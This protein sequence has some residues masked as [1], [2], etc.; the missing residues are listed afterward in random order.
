MN[1]LKITMYLLLTAIIFIGCEK[2]TTTLPENA[3]TNVQD[4]KTE[5]QLPLNSISEIIKSGV[6]LK[7]YFNS[8]P[9]PE[10]TGSRPAYSQISNPDLQF[11]YSTEGWSCN[12]MPME[13]FEDANNYGSLP[14]YLN[15][16]SDNSIFSP[17][18]ILPG[19]SFELTRNDDYSSPGYDSFDW[20]MNNYGFYVW[21]DS[22]WGA[23][24]A[25]LSNYNWT[26]L[27]INFS[28]NNVTN[29]SMDL[30]NWSYTNVIIY[31]Y[32]ANDTLLGADVVYVPVSPTFWAVQSLAP[33]SK[34]V[35]KSEYGEGYEGVDNVSFGNCDDMDG[36][37]V[38]NEND[39]HP[40]SDMSEK[41]NIGGCYPNVDNKMVKNGSTM[42]DQI[43]DLIA[44]TNSQYDGENYDYLH[45]RFMTELSQ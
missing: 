35:I 4:I 8:L 40:N 32:G 31:V 1:H 17:G 41:I 23:Q 13:D 14:N 22:Y 16:N 36:D 33:I 12:N 37:G 21:T 26:D 30:L 25:L 6:D 42:M 27:T 28:A 20:Y 5:N 45:K 9:K 19:I 38:L 44:Q 34:I 10:N 24:K 3:E 15:E 43:N 11:F 29:V 7:T 39:A 18:D 2:E